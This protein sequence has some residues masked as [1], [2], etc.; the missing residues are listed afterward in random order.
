[1]HSFKP[2]CFPDDQKIKI[3]IDGRMLV[4]NR[5]GDGRYVFELCKELDK[6]L[7]KAI[8]F[9]YC[10]VPIEMPIVSDRWIL[11]PDTSPTSYLPPLLWLKIRGSL[12]CKK[13]KLDVFWATNVFLPILSGKVKKVVTVHDFRLFIA[14]E[15]ITIIHLWANR[16][17]FTRDLFKADILLANSIGTTNRLKKY[18]KLK[19]D[20]V[21]RP[22]V[23][24][25]FKPEP[26]ELVNERLEQL[27]INSPY[28]LN[29]ATWEPIKNIES[30]IHAFL[31][32]KFEGKIPNHKLVLVGKRGWKYQAVDYLIEGAKNNDIITPGYLDDEYL[33]S[34]YTGADLFVFPSINEGFGMPVL[35][36]KSCG[37]RVVTTD[38]P[39]LREAGGQDVTYIKP[40]IKGIKQGILDGLAKL[41]L[42]QLPA[43]QNSWKDSALI[44]AN[45]L[46]C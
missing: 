16:L 39:E 35:E 22:S 6:L 15:T 44:L 17:F 26:R 4:E 8:F 18:V 3:G 24:L 7:P 12:L 23:R 33:P 1:M 25:V 5:R 30:L 31:D 13:D 45:A 20:A 9:I 27:G 46:C 42:S 11:R 37:T 41:N 14:P 28:L 36:A 38:I 10:P 21:V 2:S 34:I 32:L 40:T 43:N 19:A 29:V